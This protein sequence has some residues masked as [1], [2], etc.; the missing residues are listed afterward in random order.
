MCVCVCVCQYVYVTV[1]VCVCVGVC[2]Y[3]CVC[4]CVCVC[5]CMCVSECMYFVCLI[6]IVGARALLR[7]GAI[8]VIIQYY[9]SL[10]PAGLFEGRVFSTVVGWPVFH[11]PFCTN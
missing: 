1:C 3:M 7:G 9:Y 6:C 5:V 4:V 8:N 2:I 11:V 10:N